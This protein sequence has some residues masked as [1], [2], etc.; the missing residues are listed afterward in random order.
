MLHT[1]MTHF[2]FLQST[3]YQTFFHVCVCVCVYIY[4]YIYIYSY[5]DNFF[6]FNI[7]GDTLPAISHLLAHCCHRMPC[8]PRPEM[9]HDFP[10]QV[11]FQVDYDFR[12][13]MLKDRKARRAAVH[14][15][16]KSQTRLSDRTTNNP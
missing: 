3:S 7:L 15:V 11:D 5:I 2:K 10:P 1:E 16:A 8:F 6:F 13:F 9:G 14:G 4:I 12:S